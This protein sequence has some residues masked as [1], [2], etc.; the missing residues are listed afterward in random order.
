[1]NHQLQ[2][3][4]TCVLGVGALA[5]IV[6]CLWHLSAIEQH[7]HD[8]NPVTPEP[9]PVPKTA[10]PSP[11]VRPEHAQ[12]LAPPVEA[13]AIPALAD[14][15]RDS[16]SRPTDV[17]ADDEARKQRRLERRAA[18]E[19]SGE[20][21]GVKQREGESDEDFAARKQRRLERRLGKRQAGDTDGSS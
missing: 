4:L 12:P 2:L 9:A 13:V 1:M 14:T 3:I 18:R 10:S 16:D 21:R 19:S 15:Q 7:A 6:W 11:S 20:K 5:V 17:K 8:D